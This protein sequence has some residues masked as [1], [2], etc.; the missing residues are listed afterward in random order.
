MERGGKRT[1]GREK[2]YLDVFI[3]LGNLFM[4]SHSS[5]RLFVICIYSSGFIQTPDLLCLLCVARVCPGW[6]RFRFVMSK[7][8]LIGCENDWIINASLRHKAKANQ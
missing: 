8:R 3:E 5:K 4:D 6:C 7:Y 2:V 1:N